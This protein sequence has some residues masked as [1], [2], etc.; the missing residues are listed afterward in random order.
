MDG[1]QQVNVDYQEVADL[2]TYRIA[3]P[4]FT[5]TLP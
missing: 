1:Y 5:M 2:D 4:L 3:S